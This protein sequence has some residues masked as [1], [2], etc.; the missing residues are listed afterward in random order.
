MFAN[1]YN[2]NVLISPSVETL[3]DFSPVFPDLDLNH[4]V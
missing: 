3:L 2:F 1:D 4:N